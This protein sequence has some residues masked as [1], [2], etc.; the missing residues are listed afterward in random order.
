MER[1]GEARVVGGAVRNTL[2]GEAIGDIDIA[3]T[4]VPDVVARAAKSAGLGVHETGILH[5]TLTLVSDG[6]PFEVTTLREDVS[7]DGRRASVR[8][9]TDWAVDARRRD[10][11]MNALYLDRRGVG[12]DYVGGYE[13]CLAHRV[14]FI[15]DPEARIHEDHLR[16]LRFFRFHAAY[17]CGEPDA[18]SLAAVRAHGR[19]LGDLAVERVHTEI[20][21]LLA[22]K[23]AAPMLEILAGDGMLDAY[24]P[25]P[26]NIPAFRA[27]AAAERT[28]GRTPTPVLGIAALV[29]FSA[30]RFADVAAR[31][32]FSRKQ[33]S[34]GLMA[35]DA[36]RSMPPRSVPH[37]RALLYE[38]GAKAFADGLLVAVAQGVDV[39]DVPHLLGEARRWQRPRFPVS[40]HDLLG[41][42]GE[43]G[44]DLGER[45]DR[46]ERIWRDTDF[47]LD[48]ETLLAIDREG[49]AGNN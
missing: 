6:I 37:V 45:L 28:T 47:T 35:I 22:A 23:G 9:T 12:Y 13:D 49:I 1:F 20:L 34:R 38:H 30:S 32:R 44:P 11:T 5:G 31:L 43:G 48:R 21:S 24:I 3:T 27:L 14:R 40:G 25:P 41:Q 18:E 15:G 42:G 26:V 2:L 8:F 46:L 33:K 29:S 17:G 4:V 7:T 19:L 36:A 39:I 16:I 10:F